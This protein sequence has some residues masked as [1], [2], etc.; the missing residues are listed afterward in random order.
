MGTVITS[1]HFHTSEKCVAEI[2]TTNFLTLDTIL[3]ALMIDDK[4]RLEYNINQFHSS[5]AQFPG[6]DQAWEA[7]LF[8]ALLWMSEK[9]A[10][11]VVLLLV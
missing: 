2:S 3:Q 7:L 8:L 4:E 11:L 5:G 1:L 9:C 6:I 10:G